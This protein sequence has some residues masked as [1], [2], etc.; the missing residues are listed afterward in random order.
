[1]LHEISTHRCKSM[2]SLNVYQ[3]YFTKNRNEIVCVDKALNYSNAILKFF[4]YDFDKK[5]K[6]LHF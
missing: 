6:F 2:H 4:E 5:D 3:N 1:M